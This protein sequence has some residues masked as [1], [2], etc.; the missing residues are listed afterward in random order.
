MG[1]LV[2]R[3]MFD[4]MYAIGRNESWFSDMAKKGLH[5]KKF[6]RIFIYFEKGKSKETKYRIDMIKEAP[7]QEQLDVYQAC[8][9]DIVTNNGNLYVFSADEKAGATELHTDPI[10]QGFSLSELNKRL[11]INLIITSIAMLLFLGMIFSI[12]FLTNEPFLYMIKSQFVQQMLLVIVELYVFYSVIRN[13]VA[14]R[15]LRESLL[16]GKTINHKEDYRK[17]R[18]VGGILLGLVLSMALF[19][20]LIPLVDIA[21]SKDY[22][23]PEANTNL[24]IVR[25]ADIEQNPKLVRETGYTD[26]EVDWAN[27]VRYDWSLLAPIQ[28]EI[29]E[30]GIIKGE[31]WSD[32]SGEYSPSIITRYY[33][34]IFGDMAENLTLDLINRHVWRDNIE[35][36]E[37]NN[38]KLDKIY[39]AEDGSRKQ[40]FA[41]LD[42]R[43]IHVTY[44]G[45]KKMEDIIPFVSEKLGSYQE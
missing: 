17:A 4:D 32:K 6:G 26:N 23:L 3:V 16:Q 43:V 40:I 39:I 30:H 15:N 24:P 10:V 44:Y 37:V 7:S 42:N 1:K 21:K 5:L 19:T 11:R 20:I 33:K 13:Y 27:R 12:Y 29:Y 14:I 34:L 41:Y 28:Y 25:L 35:I 8:G 38:L 2:K 45:K 31:M 36:K 22:T 9:W 18:V